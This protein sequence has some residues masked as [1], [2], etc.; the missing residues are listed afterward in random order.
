MVSVE[1][2]FNDAFHPADLLSLVF[3]ALRRL[4]LLN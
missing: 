4:F 1:A 3:P 2:R